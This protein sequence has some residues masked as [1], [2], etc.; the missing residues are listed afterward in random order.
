[1]LTPIFI[2][3]F[4]YTFQESIPL[5]KATILAGAIANL[6]IIIGKPHPKNKGEYLIDYGLSSIVFPIV[7]P[8]TVAGVILNKMLP[9]ILVLIILTLY[10]IKTAIGVYSK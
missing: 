2:L 3:V 9:P 6:F 1:M 10:L 4:G 8:G 7:L 5:S